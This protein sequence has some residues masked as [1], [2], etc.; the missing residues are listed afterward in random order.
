[1]ARYRIMYWK[2]IP[3][4]FTVEGQGRTIKRQLSQKVQDKIDACAMMEGLTSTSDYA[5]NTNA[6]IGSNA[7]VLLKKLRMRFLPNWK[8]IPQT[9]RFPNEMRM[10]HS[11]GTAGQVFVEVTCHFAVPLSLIQR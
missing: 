7:T 6:G 2:H 10:A 5:R 4:S 11:R 8:L 1:M 9:L 3:Q